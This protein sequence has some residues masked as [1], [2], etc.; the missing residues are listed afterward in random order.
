MSPFCLPSLIVPLLLTIISA[1]FNQSTESSQTGGGII[2]KFIDSN[3]NKSFLMNRS[4]NEIAKEKL[5]NLQQLREQLVRR[6]YKESQTQQLTNSQGQTFSYINGTTDENKNKNIVPVF[7]INENTQ[8][9]NLVL[10]GIA[11]SRQQ[12]FWP[13]VLPKVDILRRLARMRKKLDPN[14]RNYLT[15]KYNDF[16][17]NLGEYSGSIGISPF[18]LNSLK[19]TQN[20]D[21]SWNFIEQ[22]LETSSLEQFLSTL[23]DFAT[24]AKQKFGSLTSFDTMQSANSND[25][26]KGRSDDDF[27]SDQEPQATSKGKKKYGGLRL[28]N[29]VKVYRKGSSG[30]YEPHRSGYEYGTGTAGDQYGLYSHSSYDSS[31]GK[32]YDDYYSTKTLHD[33]GYGDYSGKNSLKGKHFNVCFIVI[34]MH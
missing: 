8:S 16:L 1:H 10:N 17:T 34:T 23:P 26:V 25:I 32:G 2:I 5:A 33:K 27:I 20:F 14:L 3:Q 29:R 12:Q 7:R 9:S 13:N 31:Y 18:V 24:L 19:I 21:Q 11:D 6:K 15:T 22:M 30:E 4:F 28:S